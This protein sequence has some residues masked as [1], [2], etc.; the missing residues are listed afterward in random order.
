[1]KGINKKLGSTTMAKTQP[2][3]HLLPTPNTKGGLTYTQNI[4]ASSIA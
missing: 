4:L 3:L 1:V 2:Q